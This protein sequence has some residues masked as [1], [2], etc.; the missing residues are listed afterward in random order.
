MAGEPARG[1]SWKPFAEGHSVS[2]R[3]GAWSERRVSPLAQEL[4]AGLLADRPDLERFPETVCAW[5]RAE[6]RC[7]MFD[8]YLISDK[9]DSERALKTARYVNAFER[10]AIELRARL[11]LD[12]RSEAELARDRAQ[13][14]R[15]LVNLDAIRERGRV[16]LAE[17]E[18]VLD[19]DG[20]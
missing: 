4:V 8:A 3:H 14:S 2:T 7:L 19:V 13:A 12:P 6:A 9:P 10:L 18:E 15:E 17:R 11:G 20:T 5:A 16:A 1:Y